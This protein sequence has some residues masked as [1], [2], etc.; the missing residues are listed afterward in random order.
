M[1]DLSILR[2]KAAALREKRANMFGSILS[3]FGIHPRPA[4]PPLPP[5]PNEE[6]ATP[7]PLTTAQKI[8]ARLGQL[9]GSVAGSA[10]EGFH[11]NFYGGPQ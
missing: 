9:F 2:A 3:R 11:R 7:P 10:A 5:D 4:T 6:I 1:D 8:R